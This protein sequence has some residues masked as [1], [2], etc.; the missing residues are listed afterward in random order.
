MSNDNNTPDEVNNVPSGSEK[1]VPADPFTAPRNELREGLYSEILPGLWQGGTHDDDGR[2]IHAHA[3]IDSRP[4]TTD[5]FDVVGTFYAKSNP[6]DWHVLELRYPFMDGNLDDANMD[7][8]IGVARFMHSEWKRGKR[9]LTR[10]QAGWNRSGLVTAL[11]LLIE[12]YSAEAAI[13]LIRV[14]RS[15]DALCNH[16]FERFLRSVTPSALGPKA[17]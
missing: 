4:I 13:D 17:A 10:C 12:G 9:V 1:P 3:H 15:S 11:I 6:A 16:R 7:Y 14:R 2:R 5:E 8:L